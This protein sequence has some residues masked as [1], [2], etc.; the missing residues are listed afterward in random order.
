M[1]S[2]KQIDI[3]LSNI[4]ST[5]KIIC[6]AVSDDVVVINEKMKQ[7]LEDFTTE[8]GLSASVVKC[9][10]G[11]DVMVVDLSKYY[12]RT[13]YNTDKS[14]LSL[15]GKLSGVPIDVK[16]AKGDEVFTNKQ[17]A[18]ALAELSTIVAAMPIEM[19]AHGHDDWKRTPGE[20]PKTF[21][22]MSE[23]EIAEATGVPIAAD[24]EVPGD[25]VATDIEPEDAADE[26]VDDI[27]SAG[28]EAELPEAQ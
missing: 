7:L 10:G 21:D 1:A 20:Y 3:L 8:T 22:G 2:K 17:V 27:E 28:S 19:V 5:A 15:K 6:D 14:M 12:V 11:L 18:D 13:R 24:A 9:D 4:L 16:V 25:E 26:S 23:H